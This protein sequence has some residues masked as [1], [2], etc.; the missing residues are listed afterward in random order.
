MLEPSPLPE[1]EN[2]CKSVPSMKHEAFSQCSEKLISVIK[3]LPTLKTTPF[4]NIDSN[5]PFVSNIFDTNSSLKILSTSRTA[6]IYR[7]Q[8]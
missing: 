8:P 3:F 2:V 5:K 4:E 1:V 7:L 6:R